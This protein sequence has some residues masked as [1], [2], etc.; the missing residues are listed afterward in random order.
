MIEPLPRLLVLTDR[1]QLPA[2]ADLVSALRRCADAG[3]THVVLRELDLDAQRRTRLTADLSAIGLRV[4]VAHGALAGAWGAHLA[5]RQDAP[6][7]GGLR[8]GQSCH[9]RA[10]VTAAARRGARWVTL[11]PFAPTPSKPGHGPPLA[12]QAYAG[13][14]LPVYALGGITPSNAGAAA[15]AGAHGVA[16]MG[17]VMRAEDPGRMVSQLLSAL[18]SA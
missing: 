4:V 5:S 10:E 9:D 14:R 7:A 12:P 17:E 15:A 1:H 8:F 3:L 16:V 2:G 13:H 18:D 11:S 6:A